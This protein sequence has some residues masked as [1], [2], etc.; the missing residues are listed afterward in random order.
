MEGWGPRIS[1]AQMRTVLD[2]AIAIGAE[3]AC[4]IAEP[5]EE[6]PPREKFVVVVGAYTAE[7]LDIDRAI[8]LMKEKLVKGASA[9][10]LRVN[11]MASAL[12]EIN[13]DSVMERTNDR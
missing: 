13:N 11:A 6:N 12:Y 2:M 1:L 10:L 9:E 3:R 8:A 7:A 5:N 4:V